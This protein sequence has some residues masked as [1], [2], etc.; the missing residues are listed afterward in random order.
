VCCLLLA[1]AMEAS[2]LPFE[3]VESSG[4]NSDLVAANSSVVFADNMVAYS[5]LSVVV[6]FALTVPAFMVV[7]TIIHNKSL[8]KYHYWFVANLMVYDILTVFAIIP[9]NLTLFLQSLLMYRGVGE[10]KV[11]SL[12]IP[13]NTQQHILVC[14]CRRSY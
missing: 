8:Y 2:G 9:L 7:T 3:L 10:A 4:L 5:F 1:E 11:S 14:G 12:L 13:K 6:L